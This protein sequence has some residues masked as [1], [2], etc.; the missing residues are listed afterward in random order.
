MSE[1][2]AR[3]EALETIVCTL[4]SLISAIDPAAR[5]ALE[6][7]ADSGAVVLQSQP[8]REEQGPT[9]REIERILG[10]WQSGAGIGSGQ[11]RPKKT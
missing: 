1:S 4:M 9:Y 5:A 10:L 3:I 7:F 6:N 8:G 11:L 2:D